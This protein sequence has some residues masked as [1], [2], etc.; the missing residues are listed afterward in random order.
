[1]TLLT[2]KM[3][4]ER[5]KVLMQSNSAMIFVGK[6]IF[7]P[8]LLLLL[9]GHNVDAHP[10]VFI[11]QKLKI[12]FDNQGLAGVRVEWEFDEMFSNLI[13]TDYDQN[14]N[15][16]LEP[17]EIAMVKERAFSYIGEYNYFIFIKVNGQAF[18][19]K[20]I[21]DFNAVLKKGILSYHFFVPCHVKANELVKQIN[22]STYD[23][24]YYTAIFFD[25]TQPVLIEN[26]Y[27]FEI[28]N[29]ISEDKHTSIYFGTVNPWILFL[30]FRLKS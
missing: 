27:R 26:G 25:Q 6:K 18:K 22:I 7:F 4:L 23:P 9:I 29:S 17:A 16:T 13:A 15:S 14:Q 10:H 12:V 24:S 2:G 21:K 1:M 19:V 28:T 3:R 11:I 8:L 5:E 30:K 20:W